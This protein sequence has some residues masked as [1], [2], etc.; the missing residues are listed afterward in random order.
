MFSFLT[1][2]LILV[3]ANV[4]FM[5]FSLTSIANWGKSA[6]QNLVKPASE[7]QI[8]ESPKAKPKKT[9]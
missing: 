8:L 2:L 3:G 6:G 1:I 9:V 7:I 5:A 4:L